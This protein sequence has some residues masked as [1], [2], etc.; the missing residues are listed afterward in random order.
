MVLEVKV[1]G[2]PEC[3]VNQKAPAA[4]PMHPWEWPARPWARIHIDYAGPFLGKIFLIMVDTHSKW[5]EVEIMLAA[6]TAHTVQKLRAMFTHMV[7]LS[8]WCQTTAQHL[9]VQSSRSS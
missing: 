1:H 7:Y 5:L 3:Q 8:C 9:Q 4:A 6:T 2:C